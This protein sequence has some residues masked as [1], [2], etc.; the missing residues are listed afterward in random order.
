MTL[1]T[2]EHSK[3]QNTKLLQTMEQQKSH[4]LFDIFSYQVKINE[5]Q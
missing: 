5:M 3:D 2:A 4:T 1:I